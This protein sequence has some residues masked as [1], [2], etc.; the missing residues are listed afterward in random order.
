[1]YVDSRGRKIRT[2]GTG[3]IILGETVTVDP[4]DYG[5]PE[6]ATFHI[7]ADVVAG[8]EISCENFVYSPNAERGAEFRTTG[9]T[10]SNDLFFNGF[11][12][13]WG[14]DGD[15]APEGEMDDDE[16]NLLL[17]CNENKSC[18]CLSC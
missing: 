7:Y 18:D 16:F 17:N 9:T 13:V 5:V 4:G 1:M 10:L 6:G 3:N 14:S 12:V 11:F 8:R 15:C 2:Q